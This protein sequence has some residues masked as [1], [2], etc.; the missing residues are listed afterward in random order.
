[1]KIV[2]IVI[3]APMMVKTVPSSTLVTLKCEVVPRSACVLIRMI[4]ISIADAIMIEQTRTNL[5]ESGKYNM[6]RV[7]VKRKSAIENAN[8]AG[9]IQTLMPSTIR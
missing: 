4:S 8:F 7:I 2:L 1:M 5:S 3:A 6:N 9:L